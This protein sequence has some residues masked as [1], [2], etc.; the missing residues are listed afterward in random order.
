MPRPADVRV[1]QL[2]TSIVYRWPLARLGLQQPVF[3]L[4][5]T[6]EGELVTSFTAHDERARRSDN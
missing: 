6:E 2:P 1:T 5:W 3:V 4:R